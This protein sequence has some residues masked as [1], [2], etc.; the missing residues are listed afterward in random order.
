MPFTTELLS[1]Y[2]RGTNEV[3]LLAPLEYRCPR[4]KQTY[5]V[6][7]LFISDFASIPR[8]F[9]T[10]VGHPADH[11]WR[12]Q[13]VLHDFLCRTGIIPRKVADQIYYDSLREGG[14]GYLQAQAIYFAVRMGSLTFAPDNYIEKDKGA[15]I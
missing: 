15:K 8:I 13:S 11:R 1:S 12:E 14:L 10:L 6:P 4:T 2:V 5:V 9:W 7:K 3:L